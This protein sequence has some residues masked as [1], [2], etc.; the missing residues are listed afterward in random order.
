[1]AERVDFKKQLQAK[2]DEGK[3]VCLGLDPDPNKLPPHIENKYLTLEDDSWV[4]FNSSIV[5]TTKDLVCAYKTNISF[6]E[7][8][9]ALQDALKATV[10]LIHE[11]APGVPVIGDIKKGD[12]PHAGEHHARMAFERYKFDAVNVHPYMGSETFEPFLAYPDKEVFVVCR[13]SNP[14]S[15][16]M[17]KLPVDLW[18]AVRARVLSQNEYH[19]LI[20]IIKDRSNTKSVPLYEMVAFLTTHR[21][22]YSNRLGLVMGATDPYAIESIRTITSD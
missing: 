21:W 4:E 11:T 3:F 15:G 18:E 9:C 8:S 5:E 7:G 22:N 14:D 17:Q 20:G 12:V 6:Y 10:E 2:W 13:T 19:K 16:E 1:M